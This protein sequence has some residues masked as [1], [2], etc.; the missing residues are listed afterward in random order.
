MARPG[1]ERRIAYAD[2]AWRATAAAEWTGRSGFGT[3]RWE[4]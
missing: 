4:T 2:P 1:E 3:P